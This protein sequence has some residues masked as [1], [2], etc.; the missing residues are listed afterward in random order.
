[1]LAWQM[2]IA[3]PLAFPPFFTRAT[4]RPTFEFLG[5]SSSLK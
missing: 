2:A 4:Q 5:I 3:A 1:V